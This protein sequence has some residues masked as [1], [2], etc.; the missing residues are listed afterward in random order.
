MKKMK[1]FRN[2]LL[3]A[4]LMVVLTVALVVKALYPTVILPRLNI[5]NI[6]LLS[7]IVL[8]LESWLYPQG[9][10]CWVCTLVLAVL[11]FGLLPFAAGVAELQGI[12]KLGLVG[13]A[14]FTLIA[15][16]MD[17][18]RERLASGPQAKGA[19]MATALGVYLASQCFAGILL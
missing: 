17:S 10:N 12:W 4:V 16:A 19:L 9:G 6:V 7:L 14:V 13:G 18:V 11:S 5:P 15:L 3:A 8:L 2:V 1:N